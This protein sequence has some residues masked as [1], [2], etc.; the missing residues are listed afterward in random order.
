MKLINIS[1]KCSEKRKNLKIYNSMTIRP[2]PFCERKM[3]ESSRTVTKMDLVPWSETVW[4]TTVPRLRI[5]FKFQVKK[6]KKSKNQTSLSVLEQNIGLD[7]A[8]NVCVFD[9]IILFLYY[10]NQPDLITRLYTC[11]LTSI[12]MVTK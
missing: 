7:I 8:P 9:K 3:T 1:D 11:T 2:T 12:I 5:H 4:S 10:D 6:K